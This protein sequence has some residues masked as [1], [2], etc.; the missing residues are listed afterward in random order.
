MHDVP[1][2]PA[3]TALVPR[4]HP[5]LSWFAAY[6]APNR[7]KKTAASLSR[8]GIESFLPL[9]RSARRWSDRCV[10]LERPLFPGYL[11]VQIDLRERVKV[12]QIP[13]VVHLVGFGGVPIALPSEQIESIRKGMAEHANVEP[14]PYLSVGRVVRF[15]TGP[16]LGMSGILLRRKGRF[17]VVI[18]I[19]LI[20]RSMVVNVEAADVEP[21]G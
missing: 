10:T 1:L 21:V 2:N 13:G 19:E 5:Q 12:L 9:Y 8:S 6:I 7:E 14:Y 20:E 17:R 15:R 11:F 16:F 4:T 18:S 3:E